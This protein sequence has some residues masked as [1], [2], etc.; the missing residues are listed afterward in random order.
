MESRSAAHGHVS[1]PLSDIPDQAG[2]RVVIQSRYGG[3]EVLRL[4]RRPRPRPSEGEV[5]VRVHAASVNA[6][7]WHV[8]RGEPRLARLL[9]RTLF[10]A[11][12]PRAATRGTDLAG[13]VEAI[14]NGVTAWQ[15]GDAVFGE[16]IGT[17]ADYAVASAD[18]LAAVPSGTSFQ[19]AA[20]LPLAATTALLCL[21][22]ARLKPGSSVLVNGASGGVGTFVV[23]V[24]KTRGLHVTAVVSTRNIAL[25]RSAGA[26]AVIDY[27]TT[28]FTRTG[29][30]YDAVVDLVGNRRLRDLRRSVRPGGSL[31]LSGGGTPGTGRFVG[32][33][34]LLIGAMAVARFQPFAVTVPQ[35]VP[36]SRTLAHI[37]D[38]V[39]SG[40]LRPLIDRTFPLQDAAEAI[41][42]VE[43]E[44]PRGKVVLTT[45]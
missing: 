29:H 34:R 8:M 37:A 40:S 27:T 24:A 38:L 12:R 5:L 23:Q 22:E 6:R 45:A 15:P 20:T 25:A 43:T 21:E 44:H 41:R 1:G 4:A 2:G 16:G 19:E 30:T 3:P 32:P 10:G 18:Q 36:N 26:D 42:Y 13:V 31:V 28:D 39:G 9:D 17:F 7:D 33:M 14:G 11:R 35:A